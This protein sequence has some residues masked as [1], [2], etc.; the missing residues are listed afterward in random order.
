MIPLGVL[1]FF[2]GSELG[3][4]HS[5]SSVMVAIC[6]LNVV[7]K[8][9]SV[10]KTSSL[11]SAVRTKLCIATIVPSAAQVE[12]ASAM[13]LGVCSAQTDAQPAIKGA[14]AASC[15]VQEFM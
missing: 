4:W 14:G 6:E 10:P 8:P 1:A 2:D 13:V 11:I 9:F 5:L 15:S 12:L 7:N 3:A